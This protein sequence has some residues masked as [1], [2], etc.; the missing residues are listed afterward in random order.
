M[1]SLTGAHR[2]SPGLTGADRFVN[3][4][5]ARPDTCP[6]APP[7]PTVF[8]IVV[9]YPRKASGNI[10]YYILYI[11]YYILSAHPACQGMGRVRVERDP[12]PTSL[13]AY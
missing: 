10:I 12:G 13:L 4:A 1:R 9:D 6:S 7:G 8:R 2:G 3:L 11:I 5:G